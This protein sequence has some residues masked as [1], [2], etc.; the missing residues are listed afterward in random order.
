MS[1]LG[2][3]LPLQARGANSLR[4]SAWFPGDDL[5]GCES[6]FVLRSLVDGLPS[7]SAVLTVSSD[8]GDGQLTISD[9]TVAGTVGGASFA[10]GDPVVVLELD[11]DTIESV[12]VGVYLY[13]W[14]L[15]WPNVG[16]IQRKDPIAYGTFERMPTIN[17]S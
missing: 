13:E 14:K 10:V 9:S 15:I 12:A 2:P 1:T 7:G 6:T 5:T 8:D 17:P 3:K 11:P 16:S 4:L